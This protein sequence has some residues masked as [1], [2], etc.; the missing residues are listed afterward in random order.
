MA[1]PSFLTNLDVD[2]VPALNRLE[3]T[4]PQE[5]GAADSTYHDALQRSLT[6]AKPADRDDGCAVKKTPDQDRSQKSSGDSS[7]RYDRPS[8]RESAN[9]SPSEIART[10]QASPAEAEQPV[11]DLSEDLNGQTD[12]APPVEIEATEGS[13]PAGLTYEQLTAGVEVPAT[14][15]IV[16]ETLD[17]IDSLQVELDAIL[18]GEADAVDG[19]AKP[20]N[21]LFEITVDIGAELVSA[22]LVP[23]TETVEIDAV[24]ELSVESEATD[25]ESLPSEPAAEIEDVARE[26]E[27]VLRVVGVESHDEALQADVALLPEEASPRTVSAVG[28][29]SPDPT[30]PEIENEQALRAIESAT[31]ESAGPELAKLTNAAAQAIESTEKAHSRGD[32]EASDEGENESTTEPHILPFRQ[33]GTDKESADDDNGEQQTNQDG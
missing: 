20:P 7:T 9:S 2:P 8:Q 11:D 18:S 1:T 10:D 26:A 22:E 33:I 27:S 6:D 3:P 16:S 32:A 28:A 19:L 12:V 29:N 15:V 14:E 23:E 24:G 30:R 21:G 17:L 5:K 31:S 13:P 4:P 25:T